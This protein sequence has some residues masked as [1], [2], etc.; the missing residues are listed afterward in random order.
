MAGDIPERLIYNSFGTFL[1][2]IIPPPYID[3][4]KQRGR[5]RHKSASFPNGYTAKGPIKI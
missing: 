4:F 1:A 5:K 3:V 2:K